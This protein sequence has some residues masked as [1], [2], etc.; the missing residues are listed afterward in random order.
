MK[1]YK[2]TIQGSGKYHEQYV[3]ADNPDN[4]YNLVRNFLDENDLYFRKDRALD[5]IQLLADENKYEDI[6]TLLHIDDE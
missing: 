5:T 3:V 4:A 1:L 6:Q 2:V